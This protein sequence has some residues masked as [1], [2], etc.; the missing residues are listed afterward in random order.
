VQSLLNAQIN[1]PQAMDAV[2]PN[3]RQV[4]NRKHYSARKEKGDVSLD[5]KADM[6][7]WNQGKLFPSTKDALLQLAEDEVLILPGARC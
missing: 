4:A 2:L 1:S 6:Q 7:E 5:S 3:P